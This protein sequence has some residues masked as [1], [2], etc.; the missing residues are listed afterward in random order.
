[1]HCPRPNCKWQLYSNQIEDHCTRYH[2]MK[3]NIFYPSFRRDWSK[4]TG[5]GQKLTTNK[6]PQFLS[7]HHETW[8]K[9]PPQQYVILT[10]FHDDSTKIVDFLLIVN[11]RPCPVFLSVSMLDSEKLQ[12]FSI[13][14]CLIKCGI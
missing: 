7:Y 4:K 2:R 6:N 1:M 12:F 10:K 3:V 9:K 11:F 5:Q 13:V 8:P 14:N